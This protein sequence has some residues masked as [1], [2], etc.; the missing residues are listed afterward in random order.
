MT[1]VV[2]IDPGKTGAVIRLE[3]ETGCLELWRDFNHEHELAEAVVEAA[4]GCQ[5]AAI[6]NVYSTPQMGVVSSFTFGYWTGV[7]LGACKAAGLTV[8]RPTPMTWQRAV[9]AS[10]DTSRAVAIE[11]FPAFAEFFARKKDHN[12]ADAALLALWLARQV[13]PAA[14]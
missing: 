7:A 10:P 2:G 6:E 12:S 14:S 5:H 9:G 1:A 13:A 8:H 11:R 4:R 3:V